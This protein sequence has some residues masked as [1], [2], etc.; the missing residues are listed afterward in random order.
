[1]LLSII[2]STFS[3]MTRIFTNAIMYSYC[4]ETFR[5]QNPCLLSFSPT[6]LNLPLQNRN[7]PSPSRAPLPPSPPQSYLRTHCTGS[8]TPPCPYNN[9]SP[10]AL[11]TAPLPI[12]APPRQRYQTPWCQTLAAHTPLN[13][14][15]RSDLTLSCRSESRY[16][17]VYTAGGV[18]R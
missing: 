9:A 8:G 12:P 7:A 5:H 3:Y 11:C 17:P 15:D 4:P 1:M 16:T 10:A 2:Y 14:A 13:K 18:L 6:L